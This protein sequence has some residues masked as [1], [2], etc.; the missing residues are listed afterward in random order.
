MVSSSDGTTNNNNT[1]NITVKVLRGR[2][3]CAFCARMTRFSRVLIVL[4]RQL[5]A[6]QMYRKKLRNCHAVGTSLIGIVT[7]TAQKIERKAVAWK[8]DIQHYASRHIENGRHSLPSCECNADNRFFWECNWIC[9]IQLTNR[10][11]TV[12]ESWSDSIFQCTGIDELLIRM[13]KKYNCSYA[14]ILDRIR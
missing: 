13:I 11:R 4:H 14:S 5:P 1:S 8:C 7:V 10:N 3:Q 12:T 6:R 9:S 2:V